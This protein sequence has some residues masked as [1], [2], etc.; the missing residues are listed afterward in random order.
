MKD[1][2]LD[3]VPDDPAS[4]QDVR[5]TWLRLR[6]GG[7]VVHVRI[8]PCAERVAQDPPGLL[9]CGGQLGGGAWGHIRLIPATVSGGLVAAD[10]EYLVAPAATR[11]DDVPA[12]LTHT[13]QP[14]RRAQ[15]ELIC[16][17]GRDRLDEQV[18]KG[19]PARIE[20]QCIRWS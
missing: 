16:R 19:V 14:R 2:M 3:Q 18:L 8:A 13:P 15:V 9:Q 4:C 20:A 11:T 5:L 7:G 1:V 17:Q 6:V 12:I 10:L